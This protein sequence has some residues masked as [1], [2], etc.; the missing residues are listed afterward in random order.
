MA[1]AKTPPC[2]RRREGA[3]AGSEP[4]A[5]FRRARPTPAGD[6]LLGPRGIFG[7][8]HRGAAALVAPRPASPPPNPGGGSRGHPIPP[9]S[10]VSPLRVGREGKGWAPPRGCGVQ[11]RLASARRGAPQG[12]GPRRQRRG[13][14]R[15]AL[16]CGEVTAW[17]LLSGETS[18][19]TWRRGVCYLLLVVVAK[20][21]KPVAA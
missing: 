4:L 2:A 7:E 13:S 11:S 8:P 17:C 3:R 16:L 12:P 5:M 15:L 6:W 19:R 14:G 18:G 21:P 9:V 10:A 1:A 20:K